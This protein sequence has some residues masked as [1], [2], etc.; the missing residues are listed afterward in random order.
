MRENGFT[1]H[2]TRFHSGVISTPC[3]IKSVSRA[4]SP[5]PLSLSHEYAQRND[6]HKQR[7]LVF[8]AFNLP[9]TVPPIYKDIAE[10]NIRPIEFLIRG[11]MRFQ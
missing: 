7:R 1:F 2:R 11:A 3:T 10:L 8:L 5:F 6:R 9:C 4:T